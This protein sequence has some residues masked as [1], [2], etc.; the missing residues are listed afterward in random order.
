MQ[1]IRSQISSMSVLVITQRVDEVEEY[2]DRCAFI[3][4][5]VI[6]AIGTVQ[7]L[8]SKYQN[9][10]LLKIWVPQDE[11]LFSIRKTDASSFSLSKNFNE[12]IQDQ[13]PF[14]NFTDAYLNRAFYT[15]N[16]ESVESSQEEQPQAKIDR[17][18]SFAFIRLIEMKN[19]GLIE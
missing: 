12:E 16:I 5:G 4:N 19:E 6:V 11:A 9:K 7:E 2:C 13:L 18:L 1:Y 17:I 8:L 14:C 3:A 10:H 15:I